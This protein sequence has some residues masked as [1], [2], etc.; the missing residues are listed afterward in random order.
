MGDFYVETKSRSDQE[1]TDG[2]SNA[3]TQ[4]VIAAYKS[5]SKQGS[6]RGTTLG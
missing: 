1:Y 6:V 5:G 4:K 2:R 3:K